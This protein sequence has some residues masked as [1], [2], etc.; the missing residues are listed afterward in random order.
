MPTVTKRPRS[1]CHTTIFASQQRQHH[2]SKTAIFTYNTLTIKPIPI[3]TTP[4]KVCNLSRWNTGRMR[5]YLPSYPSNFVIANSELTFSPTHLHFIPLQS[6][7]IRL[8]ESNHIAIRSGHSSPQEW[9]ASLCTHALSTN[10]HAILTIRQR[11]PQPV[12]SFSRPYHP[13][14]I[15]IQQRPSQPV[16]L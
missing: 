13:Q 14:T 2:P 9:R 15:Q 16:K 8:R 11:A 4:L 1:T 10:Q 7:C 12:K 3:T 6:S 5:R